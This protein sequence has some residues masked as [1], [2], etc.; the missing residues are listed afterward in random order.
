MRSD[1]EICGGEKLLSLNE[2]RE[3][4]DIVACENCGLVWNRIMRDEQG[5]VEYYKK[6]Y[7]ETGKISRR[8]LISV[9]SRAASVLNFLSDDL[10]PGMRH[11]D[12]GCADGTLLAL[13]RA[14]GLDVTGLEL[15]VNYSRFAREVRQLTVLPTTIEDTDL[16]PDSFELVSFVH[17]L[18]HLFHPICTL[19]QARELLRDNGWLYVEVPNLCQPLPGPRRFFRHQHNFYFTANT[20][21][22]LVSKAGFVPVRIACSRRDVS[23]QVL[24]VKGDAAEISPSWRDDAQK[25]YAH[26]NTDRRRYHLLLRLLRRRIQQER[27]RHWA[28]DRYGD[29]LPEVRDFTD[30]K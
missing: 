24:A 10:K 28:L 1:C 27:L 9:L 23:L 8:Y 14:H 11:L 26:V 5:Q 12:V 18:E 19:R 22:S 21:R 4:V 3:D 13:T 6:Q 16:A 17:V 30:E 15:D 2:Q 29:M 20:L 25:I 7:R